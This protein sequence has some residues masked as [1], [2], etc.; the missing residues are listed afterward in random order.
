MGK[1]K[2]KRAKFAH[3]KVKPQAVNNDFQKV[4]P[5]LSGLLQGP[6]GELNFYHNLN[7]LQDL[8][9]SGAHPLY[10]FSPGDVAVLAQTSPGSKHLPRSTSELTLPA[11]SSLKPAGLENAETQHPPSDFVASQLNL[12]QSS[13]TAASSSRSTTALVRA[14]LRLKRQRAERY[15]KESNEKRRKSGKDEIES[16]SLDA[17]RALATAYIRVPPESGLSKPAT[18]AENASPSSFGTSHYS[19]RGASWT[20][21][22][23][24]S[25]TVI[26]SATQTSAAEHNK[27]LPKN[28]VARVSGLG[29]GIAATNDFSVSV[30]AVLDIERA[31]AAGADDSLD[32]AVEPD[33]MREDSYSPPAAD[34]FP[35]LGETRSPAVVNGYVPRGVQSFSGFTF[36][37]PTSPLESDADVESAS[38]YS[39][40]PAVAAPPFGNATEDVFPTPPPGAGIPDSFTART[41]VQEDRKAK[42]VK[43]PKQRDHKKEKEKT[44]K[45][46]RDERRAGKRAISGQQAVQSDLDDSTENNTKNPGKWQE[47]RKFQMERSAQARRQA[48]AQK[49]AALEAQMKQEPRS[50]I[51]DVNDNSMVSRRIVLRP[52]GG[53]DIEVVPT[54]QAARGQPVTHFGQ[55]HA[56]LTNGHAQHAARQSQAVYSLASPTSAPS[57]ARRIVSHDPNDLRRLASLQ[58]AARPQSPPPQLLYQY[59]DGTVVSAL[60]PSQVVSQRPATR[61]SL[62]H[63]EGHPSTQPQY[64]NGHSNGYETPARAASTTAA[65]LRQRIIVDEDGNEY[66]AI[67]TKASISKP[68][69][70]EP[71]RPLPA[72]DPATMSIPAPRPQRR[73]VQQTQRPGL[74]HNV[75]VLDNDGDDHV[76]MPPPPTVVR[77]QQAKPQVNFRSGEDTLMAPSPYMQPHQYH[78]TAMVPPMPPPSFPTVQTPAPLQHLMTPYLAPQPIAALGLPVPPPPPPPPPAFA[79][80]SSFGQA[81]PYLPQLQLQHQRAASIQPLMPPPPPLYPPPPPLQ[82]PPGTEPNS[83]MPYQ[84]SN[85][86]PPLQPPPRSYSTQPIPPSVPQAF[87]PVPQPPGQASQLAD[88]MRQ[89]GQ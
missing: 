19:S 27:L 79:A 36:P 76:A 65:P 53:A 56:P 75:I 34:A 15:L 72:F 8:I 68:V 64:L 20:P 13:T 45:Q 17:E 77:R 44:R 6:E 30:P 39:P 78:N 48:E 63:D 59:A 66:I 11:S 74:P 43:G 21:E 70:P 73:A 22:V 35:V 46:R 25:A 86:V 37:S 67:P 18:P 24:D 57:S 51:Q 52:D 60:E 87:A 40:P 38:D 1:N 61:Q 26:E 83:N 47:F 16:S 54:R 23:H 81:T 62:V 50:P 82:Y 31:E 89:Y 55:N 88:W 5:L 10:R 14:E 28:I 85:A 84:Y 69:A 9:L 29:P 41:K 4:A 2:L 12:P 42:K 32:S 3:Q 80:S 58:H 49:R 7:R 33:D 71:Q